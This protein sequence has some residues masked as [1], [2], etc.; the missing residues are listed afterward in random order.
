MAQI[1][2][3]PGVNL[4]PPQALYPANLLSTTGVYQ[5]ATNAITLG[6]GGVQI[7]PPGKYFID[8]GLYSAIQVNDPVSGVWRTLP[9]TG[10]TQFVDSDGVN[11]RV[12][13]LTGCPVGATVTTAGSGYTAG[14]PAV[15]VSAGGS[16]WRAVLGG[17]VSTTT[18]VTAAGS[19]Y[20]LAPL[21][22][23]PPPPAGGLQATAVAVLSGGT[24]GSLTVTNQGAGYS[25]APVPVILPNPL[26]TN[27]G[28]ITNATA[29]TALTGT[30]MVTG[31]VCLTPGT[32]QTG[33]VTLTVAAPPSGTQAVATAVMALSV[34]GYTVSTAGSG[35]SGAVE[36]TGIGG[37]VSA[38]AWTNPAY[39]NQFFTPRQ[40]Q[41]LGAVVTGAVTTA[42]S[43]VIDG[44]IY[45][46]APSPMVVGAVITGTGALPATVVLTLGANNATVFVTPL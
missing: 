32:P 23:I 31:I 5:S 19:G 30:G 37:V 2:N 22:Y 29:T 1:I 15:T 26:D 27:L 11:Y 6:G 45:Q 12:A 16:T 42:G 13:N 41:I 17:A 3:G 7:I 20:T 10:Q 14:V 18:T 9:T 24:V 43:L 38:G 33:A 39:Q 21:V 40:A 4:P 44:G 46:A 28:V 35:Y 34:T 8:I 25:T 36:V